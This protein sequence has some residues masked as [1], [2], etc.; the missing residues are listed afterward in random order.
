MNHCD[1]TCA[2]D[3]L[4]ALDDGGPD[5]CLKASFIKLPTGTNFMA[6]QKSTVS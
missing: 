1:D 3:E 5:G 6:S 2:A 4:G